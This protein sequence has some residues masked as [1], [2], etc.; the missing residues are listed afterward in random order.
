VV[1]GSPVYADGWLESARSYADAVAAHLCG[2]PTWLFSSVLTTHRRRVG[3]AGP[4]DSRDWSAVREWSAQIVTE[5]ARRPQAS[6]A[7]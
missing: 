1:L 3:A 4:S 6:G 7:G 5:L 2:R